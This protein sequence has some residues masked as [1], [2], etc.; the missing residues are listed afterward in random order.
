MMMV[1]LVAS[2]CGRDVPPP[3]AAPGNA[4]GE[5]QEPIVEEYEAPRLTP[6]ESAAAV[7]R[8]QA[9]ADSLTRA[10]RGEVNTTPPRVETP[11]MRKEHCQRQV[12]QAEG[13]IR[14]HIIEAC[15][16]MQ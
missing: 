2:G 14:E 7:T 11:E 9:R 15:L 12:E 8:V 10:V 1:L 13:Q 3:E 5:V 6:A 16:R 4:G